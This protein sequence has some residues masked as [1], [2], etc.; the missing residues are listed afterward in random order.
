MLAQL[1][2]QDL[3]TVVKKLEFEDDI[4]DADLSKV[5]GGTEGLARVHLHFAN[6]SEQN[7]WGNSRRDLLE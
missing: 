2:T 3:R 6:P 7:I 4:F 5:S 1:K